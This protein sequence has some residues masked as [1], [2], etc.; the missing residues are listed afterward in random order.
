MVKS[1]S[2]K[3]PIFDAQLFL[4]ELTAH[5]GV[6]QMFSVSDEMLYI[7][8]ARNLK[9]RLS[10]Y[11]RKQGLNNKTA[12]LVK[13]IQRIEV[14][15]TRSENEALLLEC[16]L[17]KRFKPRY[18]I[19]LRDD[20]SYPY[21]VLTM[22]PDFP[23]LDFYRGPKIGKNRYFG[24]YPSATAARETLNLLQKLFRLRS[25]QD[26]FF[27]HRQRPCLQY[28]IKRCTGPCVKLIDVQAYQEDVQRV[29]LF[30][31]G[32]SQAVI[33]D[34]VQHMDQASANLQFELAAHYRDQIARLR[35]IQQQQVIVGHQEDSDAIVVAISHGCV[36]IQ[37]MTI[38]G[39][40]LLGSKAFFP[41]LPPAY[42]EAEVL[43]AFL[44][45]Y[46]LAPEHVHDIPR[47]LIVSHA[48]AEADWLAQALV[49]QAGHAVKFIVNPRSDRARWLQMALQNAQQALAHHLA[50]R[51]TLYQR[52]LALQEL[53]GLDNLPQRLECF[54]IS[55]SQGEATVASCVVFDEGGPRKKDYRH[56]N[57]EGVTPGDDY[58]AMLQALLRRY[59]AVK[60]HEGQ[61][62]DVLIIDGGKGQLAQAEKVLE[63]LQIAG[64]AIV[65]IAKGPTRKPGLETLFMAG[66]AMPLVAK[67]D[68]LALHLIQ[69]IRDE[70]HRFAITG[71]R[72]R[73]A[74][75]RHTSILENIPGIGAKRRRELLRHFGGLQELK[76]ASIEDI[77]KVTGINKELAERIYQAL[78]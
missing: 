10:S 74:K 32:K 41:T 64:V 67:P 60:T 75:K 17:I 18:N 8:K 77:A 53:L 6:Y 5:P 65:A 40:I 48:V 51:S 73:R 38:R 72:G 11:F 29:V 55:H 9:K 66:R 76:R 49:E 21:L 61:L 16:E 23:R 1:A 2:S 58:A 15:V 22:H 30:L 42:N 3:S 56:F 36:C 57:I 37:V 62:P 13:Q 54:D 71:H 63:E 31:E 52:M 45:Q 14:I 27:R 46:Y 28:Q 44:P 35:Q 25:C 68:S 39:G 69:Q 12:A 70:A 33:D 78:L 47:Q 26:D 7:G 34:L 19:L 4:K 59:T 50:E 20:K 24:P 43:A